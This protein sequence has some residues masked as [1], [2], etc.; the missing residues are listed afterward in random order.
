MKKIT[1]F[2]KPS[3]TKMGVLIRSLIVA[4]VIYMAYFLVTYSGIPYPLNYVILGG[5]GFFV[6]IAT[7]APQVM[8]IGRK[9]NEPDI[10]FIFVLTHMLSVATSKTSN[11]NVVHSVSKEDLYKKYSK[12]F[13]RIYVLVKEFGYDFPR[14]VLIVSK[15]AAR[16]KYLK[17]FLER[18][19][20]T[21]RVGED[22]E[23]FM[24]VE[25]R[26][27]MNS[28]EYIY[29]RL[30][31]SARVLLGVYTAVMTSVIFVISNLLILSFIF[32]GDLTIILISFIASFSAL[33]AVA[34][35]LWMGMPKDLLV[36][37]GKERKKVLSLPNLV[38]LAGIATM[39][40]M[41]VLYLLYV[42]NINIYFLVIIS[43][44][45]LFISGTLYRRIETSVRQVDE[46][47]PVFARMYG[48]NLTIIPS[49][50]KALEPLMSVMFGRIVKAVTRLHTLLNNN[51]SFEVA[52][53]EFAKASGSE[54]IRRSSEILSD[55]L[56]YGGDTTKVGTI[57]SELALMINRTRRRRFQIHKTFET[58]VY[59]LHMTNIL[60]ISFITT[61]MGIFSKALVQIQTLLPF[62]PLPEWMITYLSLSVAVVLTAINSLALTATNGGLKQIF[63]YYMGLLLLLGGIGAYAS[64]ML[65]QYILQPISDIINQAMT[66]IAP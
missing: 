20:A 50:L 31:D 29:S 40:W 18:Y 49:P 34:V 54:L 64:N 59:A 66:P 8:G 3:F 47:F 27:T 57:L 28:Y 36:I 30:M 9:K 60:L 38:S 37:G 62:Y 58:S 39:M 2:T 35:T 15:D 13:K 33:T 23:R 48:G 65:I 53:K 19:A 32:G 26:N 44:T 46:D 52:I 43:G 51:I 6:L 55:T 14:A 41:F 63:I 45:I 25:L 56:K 42:I 17:D 61:L 1:K 21:V 7:Y 10:D 12:F 22:V 4:V 16:I 11:V 24:E 5:V